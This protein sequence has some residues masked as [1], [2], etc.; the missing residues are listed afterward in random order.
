M[1]LLLIFCVGGP[2][3]GAAIGSTLNAINGQVSRDFFAIVMSWDWSPAPVLA[4]GVGAMRGASAGLY[5]GVCLAIC[6]AAS[7]RL[8]CPTRLAVRSLLIVITFV[9][10]CWDVGGGAGVLLAYRWPRFWGFVFVG[11]PPRVNLP[12][13]AWVGGSICGAYAGIVI[14]T[15]VAAVGIHRAFKRAQPPTNAFEV[16]P[17]PV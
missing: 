13:F 6:A 1:R 4:I 12:G 14:G 2:L 16:L 7:T 10:V 11:V 17:I 3:C 9:L 5:V 15:I 8:Q